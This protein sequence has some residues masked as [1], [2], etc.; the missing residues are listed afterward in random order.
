M[1]RALRTFFLLACAAVC[2][3]RAH[4]ATTLYQDWFFPYNGDGY[5]GVEAHAVARDEAGNFYLGGQ[6]GVPGT[7]PTSYVEARSG[8]NAYLWANKYI[9]GV[10]IIEGQFTRGLAADRFGNVYGVGSA[11]SNDAGRNLFIRKFSAIDGSLLWMRQVDGTTRGNDEGYGTALDAD[12]NILVAGAV[13]WVG[14]GMDAWVGKYDQAGNRLWELVSDGGANLDDGAYGVCVDTLSRVYAVGSFS[15]SGSGKQIWVAKY[16]GAG[17]LLA[18]NVYGAAGDDEATACA[19][20]DGVL[21]VSGAITDPAVPSTQPVR[22]HAWLRAYKVAADPELTELATVVDEANW[23][24]AN[25]LAA[26]RLSNG[27]QAVFTVGEVMGAA[28]TNAQITRWL[29]DAGANL[30][31]NKREAVYDGGAHLADAAYGAVTDAQ[32]NLLAAGYE[33]VTDSTGTAVRVAW[34]RQYDP[35]IL[36]ESSTAYIS[37]GDA[38]GPD[39]IPALLLDEVKGLLYAAGTEYSHKNSFDANLQ[40]FDSA[41]GNRMDYWKSNGLN[42]ETGNTLRSDA[43][44]DLYLGG[45]A[46]AGLWKIKTQANGKFNGMAWR[47]SSNPYTGTVGEYINGSSLLPDRTLITVGHSDRPY[48][49]HDITVTKWDTKT[50]D[51]A[52]PE[53][54]CVPAILWQEDVSSPGANMDVGAGVTVDAAGNSYVAGYIYNAALGRNI[55]LAKYSPAGARLWTREIGGFT[56]EARPIAFNPVNGGLYVA[57]SKSVSGHGNDAWLARLNKD[58]GDIIWETLWNGTDNGADVFSSIAF[59]TG[60]NLFLAGTTAQKDMLGTFR[61][62]GLIIKYDPEGKLSEAYSFSLPGAAGVTVE[63]I[64]VDSQGKLYASGSMNTFTRSNPDGW[65]ARFSVVAV[66]PPPAPVPG[67]PC[68]LYSYPNPVNPDIA[69]ATLHWELP[70]DAA[71]SLKLYDQLGQAVRTWAYPAGAPGG[72]KGIN[73]AAW[74]G[75]NSAGGEVRQGMYYLKLAAEPIG[76]KK[77]A[78]IGIKR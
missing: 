63:A 30:W 6:H 55:W 69:P 58:T 76:C 38:D 28:A 18:Q 23:G 71:V 70:L 7:L 33:T 68:A 64:T 32:G 46:P 5:T 20:A 36:A 74:G 37:A 72:R 50:C 73:E 44:G 16:S 26:A 62:K 35:W 4:A 8:D 42:W 39:D 11:P 57:G 53:S 59:D 66:A 27:E 40:V 67:P 3:G 51:A 14:R 61:N 47:S 29:F 78:R 21:F 56:G 1:R 41:S 22:T 15:V 34:H 31:K 77:T 49:S 52:P 75:T 9:T 43:A 19:A 60:G 13:Q 24:R 45:Y 54:T 12:G 48:T 2:H 10:H 25:G 65:T 17:T